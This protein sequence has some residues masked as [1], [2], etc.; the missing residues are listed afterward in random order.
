MYTYR[1]ERFAYETIV[2][3]LGG[4]EGLFYSAQLDWF[5]LVVKK[6]MVGY[7]VTKSADERYSCIDLVVNQTYSSLKFIPV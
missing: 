3:R 4:V 7:L 5:F 6:N 2:C 1:D